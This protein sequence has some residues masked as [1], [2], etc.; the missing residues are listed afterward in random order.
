MSGE[1]SRPIVPEADVMRGVIEERTEIPAEQK[2][3]SPIQTEAEVDRFR[4]EK[5]TT[6]GGIPLEVIQNVGA[7]GTDCGGGCG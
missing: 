7:Y 2:N 3:L 4:S 5:D 1:T 6:L